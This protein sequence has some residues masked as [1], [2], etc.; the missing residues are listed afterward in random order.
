MS[1]AKFPLL[2]Q[3]IL[4]DLSKRRLGAEQALPTE[5]HYAE[6]F[7][8]TS[9]TVRRA[10]RELAAEG[11]LTHAR[12]RRSV[13]KREAGWDRRVP[14]LLGG[15]SVAVGGIFGRIVRGMRAA[16]EAQRVELVLRENDENP[17][18]IRQDAEELIRSG[19]RVIL[20]APMG[21]PSEEARA[22]D[23]WLLDR[24]RRARVRLITVDR[25]LRGG[26]ES[27]ASHVAC[28]NETGGRMAAHELLSGAYREIWWVMLGGRETSASEARVAGF[29]KALKAAGAPE[30]RGLVLGAGT[31]SM[32][33]LK[34]FGSKKTQ[35]VFILADFIALHFMAFLRERGMGSL[36]PSRLG[37]ITFDDLE[38]S[39]AFGLAA[40]DQPLETIGARAMELAAALLRNPALPDEEIILPPRLIRRP[41]YSKPAAAPDT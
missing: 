23:A 5:A 28:D 8:T 4:A 27:R 7:K 26:A 35:G 3:M 1:H 34:A 15:A 38:V 10:L 33:F 41:S 13:L 36:P 12:G 17:D 24:A 30:P 20:H 37:L 39:R 11:L 19:A 2:K 22:V 31:D 9:K 21:S 16:A 40:L 29:R 14:F 25:R 18:R 6:L 32:R